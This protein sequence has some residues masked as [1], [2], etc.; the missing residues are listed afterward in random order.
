MIQELIE[1][2]EEL[3]A[4]GKNPYL[5]ADANGEFMEKHAVKFGFL[6][7]EIGKELQYMDC[8]C[9]E[10]YDAKMRLESR[11]KQLEFDLMTIRKLQ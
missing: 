8:K 4:R 3:Y 10:F 6:I 7:E 9:K 1:L 11:V 5:A 2:A